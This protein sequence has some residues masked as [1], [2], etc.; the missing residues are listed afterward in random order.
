MNLKNDFL[1]KVLL[2]GKRSR[3]NLLTQLNANTDN[4]KKIKN[5]I[6][7]RNYCSEIKCLWKNR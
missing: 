4:K 2:I 7:K 6:K 5:K 3:F 1:K